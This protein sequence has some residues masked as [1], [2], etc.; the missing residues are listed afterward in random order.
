MPHRPD[1]WGI[2]AEWNP[3]LWVYSIMFLAAFVM[4]FR[5]YQHAK[6]WWKIGRPEVRWDRP[7]QRVE[8]AHQ[9]LDR[10]IARAG[11]ALPRHHARRD[12]VGVLCVLYRH[13]ARR[14]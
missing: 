5:F 9:I 14:D 4:F 6:L 11:P 8:P 13:D 10:S 7:G 2:P 3:A 1:F 12:C